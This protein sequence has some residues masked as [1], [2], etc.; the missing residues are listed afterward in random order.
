VIAGAIHPGTYAIL[1]LGAKRQKQQGQA[2]LSVC[3]LYAIIQAADLDFVFLEESEL[4]LLDSPLR[5]VRYNG[6]AAVLSELCPEAR[7]AASTASQANIWRH[8]QVIEKVMAHVP[9]LPVRFGTILRNVDQVQQLLARRQADFVADLAHIASRV[10]VGLRVLWTP[11]KPAPVEVI[12][13]EALLL[14]KRYLQCKAM[15]LNQEQNVRK[16]G[17]SLVWELNAS[18]KPIV[19]DIR[20]QILQTERLLLSAAYLIKRTSADAFQSQVETLCQAYP[21]L[22]FLPSGPW[23]AYHFVS[24]TRHTEYT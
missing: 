1:I 23:P 8:E 10:E 4:G 13:S 12:G 18:L 14:G 7:D 24:N 2:I 19:V 11:P 17:E 15:K 21:S 5:V 16:R 3:Y 22:A 6:L 20:M 9:T